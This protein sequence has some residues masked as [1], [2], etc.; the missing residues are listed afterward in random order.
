M[1]SYSLKYADITDIATFCYFYNGYMQNS[2]IYI[3]IKMQT[4]DGLKCY[5]YRCNKKYA[6]LTLPR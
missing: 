2:H 6:H 5:F 1:A 3:Y 4:L